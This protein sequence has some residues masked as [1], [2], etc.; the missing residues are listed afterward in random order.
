MR[1]KILVIDDERMILELTSLVLSSKGFEVTTVNNATDGY[2][3]LAQDSYALVLLDYMMPVINGLQALK[4]IRQRFPK[5]YVIMFT[6][7]GNE[8]VAVELMKAGAA[9][10]IL[11]PFS[12][13]NL[14]ERIENVLRLRDMELRNQELMAERERLLKEI[15]VW[16][17]ELEQRV[18]DKTLELERAHLEILQAEKLAALGHMS[19]GMVHEIRNPLNSISLF[20]QVLCADLGEDPEKFSYAEKIIAEVERIDGILVKLLAT[21]KRSSY[22]LRSLH[23][24]DVVEQSLA[25]FSGQCQ[26]QSIEIVRKM[27]GNSPEILADEDELGQVFSNLFSNAIWEMSEGG[28]L[29]VN[30]DQNDRELLFSVEDTGGG[31]PEENLGR[32]FDPFFTTKENGTGFGLSVV[33]RIIKNYGGRVSVDS[34]T[35]QGTTFHMA[36]PLV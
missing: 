18:A 11:K 36:I 8:E 27:A 25:N 2:Q 4:E 14:V 22:Q 6:G 34:R 30:V 33:L 9:D 12:N 21:S 26:A 17:R 16:N 1:D 28:Q 7:K 15:E 32:V 35:G 31:I 29:T 3:L 13:A 10:Y 24:E 23:I 19:A 20:A 5:T